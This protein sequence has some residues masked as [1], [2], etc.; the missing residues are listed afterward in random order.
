MGKNEG[1]GIED[2]ESGKEI[3]R[4]DVIP[5]LVEGLKDTS[6][7]A[8]CLVDIKKNN[9]GVVELREF[10]TI[11]FDNVENLRRGKL[12]YLSLVGGKG[13]SSITTIDCEIGE[14][15]DYF[16][17]LIKDVV[18][19]VPDKTILNKSGYIVKD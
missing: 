9:K 14:K 12:V 8:Y 17:K 6:V 19:A 11:L 4:I 10:D 2:F 5:A 13:F 15:D 7:I 3:L 1:T 16:K 18:N